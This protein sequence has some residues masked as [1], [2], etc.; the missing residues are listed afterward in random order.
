MVHYLQKDYI[1]D[2]K[3][4][5]GSAQVAWCR[6]AAYYASGEWRGKWAT[7][8]GGIL[9]NQALHTVDLMEWF[10]GEPTKLVASISNLTLQKEIEVEDTATIICSEGANF[11]FFATNG[12]VKSMQV[13]ITLRTETET[14]K[15]FPHTVLINDRVYNF[16]SK[17]EHKYGGKVCYGNGH[18]ALIADFYDCI[19]TGRPFSINATEA[20]KATRLILAAYR[21]NGVKID[22]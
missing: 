12:S 13:E 10:L 14:I 4:I 9:I 8:G 5:C 16:D 6:D 22:I 20:A 7:E 18:A 19:S 3:L 2:K 21:S 15:I 11:T 1:K 17:I